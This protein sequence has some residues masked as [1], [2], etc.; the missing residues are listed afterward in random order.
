MS[1]KIDEQERANDRL[2]ERLCSKRK[3]NFAEKWG[4][5]EER[6]KWTTNEGKKRIYKNSAEGSEK[7]KILLN[8]MKITQGMDS[9]NLIVARKIFFYNSFAKTYCKSI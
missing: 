1:T 8:E 9:R 4:E 2:A 6:K 3:D 7:E 5:S